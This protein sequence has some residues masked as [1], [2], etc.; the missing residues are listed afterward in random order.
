MTN[1]ETLKGQ[2]CLGFTRSQECHQG[3]VS[4]YTVKAI[5]AADVQETVRFAAKHNIRLVIKTS[6]HCYLGRSSAAHSINI[7]LYDMN[8]INVVDSFVP[9]GAPAGTAGTPAA[10][11]EGGVLLGDLYKAVHEH[12]RVAVGGAYRT[13]SAVGG[14]CQGGGHSPI[15]RYFGMCVDN[16]LQY[17][18]VTADGEIKVANVYQN[19]DL[20]WALRGGGGGTFGVVVE[21]VVRTHPAFDSIQQ[22]L[23]TVTS[24]DEASIRPAVSRFYAEQSRLDEG[25]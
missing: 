20:F 22:A 17:T 7:W 6:G 4:L 13:V 25:R 9:D 3:S 16:I 21:G 14:Y 8:K 24:N 18:V 23:I 11:M 19:Q 10:V 1:W 15:S 12:G 2:G 5:T